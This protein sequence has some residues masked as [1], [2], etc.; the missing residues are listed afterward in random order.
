MPEEICRGPRRSAGSAGR[1]ARSALGRA[2][3]GLLLALAASAPAVPAWAEPTIAERARA[4]ALRREALALLANDRPDAACPKLEES[5]RLRPSTETKLELAGCHERAGRL[6]SAWAL[7]TEID[8]AEA[9]GG[10]AKRGAEARERAAAIA[11]KLPRLAILVSDEVKALPGLAVTLDGVAERELWAARPVEPG[12]HRVSASAPGRQAFSREV[13][14]RQPGELIE[15]HVRALQPHAA[16]PAPLAADLERRGPM[17]YGQRP[18]SIH[19]NL[20]WVTGGLTL[21]GIALGSTFGGLAISTWDKVEDK[22]RTTCREPGRYLDCAQ[23]V[24]DLA[25]RAM[26]YATVSDFSFIAAGAALAGTAVLW[27]TLPADGPR[28][29]ARV[30]IAPGILGGAVVGVF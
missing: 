2:P 26:S 20:M 21:A 6:A 12:K 10:D 24:P 13:E 4:D 1:A 7:Y 27:L 16:A 17:P 8:V 23:P 14:A 19:R 30:Q 15:V 9:A 5:E 3:L 28:A 29:S 25:R 18:D 11:Q 22:A